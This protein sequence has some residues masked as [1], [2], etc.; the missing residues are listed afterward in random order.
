MNIILD[1]YVL[2]VPD[3]VERAEAYL[4]TLNTWLRAVGEE[5]S[6]HHLWLS[7]Q[8]LYA[9]FDAHCYPSWDALMQLEERMPP[10]KAYNVCTL[11]RACQAQ[12]TTPPL[13]DDLIHNQRLFYETEQVMVLPAVIAAR[14]PE[15]V[16]QA[17]RDTL[18]LAAIGHE[19][20]AHT[21]FEELAFGTA[22]DDFEERV[23]NLAFDAQDIETQQTRT[24]EQAWEMLFSPEELVQA[25]DLPSIWQDT[26]AAMRCVY[27]AIFAANSTPPTCPTVVSHPDFNQH[28]MTFGVNRQEA[29]LFKVFRKLA[30]ALT[31]AIPRNTQ[32]HHPLHHNGQSV[33]RGGISAWRLWVQDSSPGWRVHYWLYPDNSVEFAGFVKHND[34]S[35]AEPLRTFPPSPPK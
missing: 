35:I 28:I 11:F 30:L 5:G 19:A 20:H 27:K 25:D 15:G 13:L 16:A 23:L 29:L 22:P 12:L 2:A 24:V 26:P 6:A 3:R 21:V 1:P 17:L 33:Q 4:E 14:L 7:Q 10:D 31:G 32:Y 34:Y 8:A 18:V 9:M